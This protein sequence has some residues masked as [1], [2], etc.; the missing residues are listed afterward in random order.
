MPMPVP[1]PSG[2][3]E[4]VPLAGLTTLGVGGP[5]RYYVRTASVESVA[6]AVSW[7]RAEGRPLLFLG[8]GSNLVVSD[9]GFPRLLVHLRIRRVQAAP[10]NGAIELTAGAR[11]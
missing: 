7:A 1:R 3:A 6:E 2:L 8:G 5:A 9:E 11:G 4:S 10:T